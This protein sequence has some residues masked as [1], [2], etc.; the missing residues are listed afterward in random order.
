MAPPSSIPTPL[1]REEGRT[2]WTSRATS[3]SLTQ[4]LPL[5]LR[6]RDERAA[7]GDGERVEEL[8]VGVDGLEGHDVQAQ[9]RETVLLLEPREQHVRVD[10]VAGGRRAVG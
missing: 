10:E 7:A 1:V 9:A 4:R 3:I 5:L 2:R 8:Q 6:D